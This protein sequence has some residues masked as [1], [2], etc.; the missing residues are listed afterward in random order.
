MLQFTKQFTNLY[1]QP[2]RKAADLSRIRI[3]GPGFYICD[4][5]HVLINCFGQRQLRQAFFSA[6]LI[7]P[8]SEYC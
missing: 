7:Y 1:A 8:F 6:E 2:A 4:I 5:L 3:G